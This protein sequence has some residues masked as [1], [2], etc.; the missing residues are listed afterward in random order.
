MIEIVETWLNN[1]KS[2]KNIISKE[3]NDLVNHLAA[4]IHVERFIKRRIVFLESNVIGNSNLLEACTKYYLK[5]WIINFFIFSL[6]TPKELK[7]VL[8]HH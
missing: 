4:E 3:K 2:V 7:L 8:N 6:S 1:E 5:I